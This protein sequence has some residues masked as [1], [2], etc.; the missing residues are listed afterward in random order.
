MDDSR[1]P[2]RLASRA[3]EDSG[4]AVAV[5]DAELVGRLRERERSAQ[6]A[7]YDR[8]AERL[9][10]YFLAKLRD[11]G[12]ADAY[13]NEVFVRAMEGLTDGNTTVTSLNGWLRGIAANLLKQHYEELSQAR[14]RHTGHEPPTE[15]ATPQDEPAWELDGDG[16][17]PPTPADLEFLL[18]KRELWT[19]VHAAADGIGHGLR[20]VFTAHLHLSVREKRKISAAE[21]AAELDMTPARVD[22]Q[23]SRARGEVL[24]AIP[25]LVVA[26]TGA[27]RCDGLAAMLEDL[28]TADQLAA[29]RALVLKPKQVGKVLGHTTSCDVCGERAADART[30]ARW[31]LPPALIAPEDDERRRT[32]IGWLGHTRDGRALAQSSTSVVSSTAAS[33]TALALTTPAARSTITAT[34]QPT[35]RGRLTALLGSWTSRHQGLHQA[36]VFVTQN[37]AVLRVAVGAAALAVVGLVAASSPPDTT[38]E[39]VEEPIAPTST[40]LPGA[41]AMPASTPS[42]TPAPT[43]TAA[44]STS[45]RQQHQPVDSPVTFPNPTAPA[46][47]PASLAAVPTAEPPVAPSTASSS[48]VG[49]ATTS[50]TTTTT[51]TTRT[52]G[53][54]S[55]AFDVSDTSYPHFYIG[56]I[57][58]RLAGDR[59]HEVEL[60]RGNHKLHTSSG[61]VVEFSLDA[62]GNVSYDPRYD[63]VVKGRGTR[64]LSLHG[65]PVTVDASD[66]DYP[67]MG[68][69]NVGGKAPKV[70]S[71]RLL[72]GAYVVASSNGAMQAFKVDGH[73]RVD[74][75]ASLDRAFGGRGTARLEVRG[76]PVEVDASATDYFTVGIS[77]IGAVT[78]KS[79]TAKLMPGAHAALSGAV[80]HPFTVTP[81]GTVDYDVKYREVLGGS[82]SGTLILQ[83][84]P[85]TVDARDTSYGTMSLYY[86]ESNV[87][88][89]ESRTWRLMPGPHTLAVTS[90]VLVRFQV[91]LD[92]TVGNV[93]LS[94]RFAVVRGGSTLEL[95]GGDVVVDV[96]GVSY[97]DYTL[98]WAGRAGQE[99]VK[100]WKLLPGKHEL[101][102][103]S[104]VRVYFSVTPAGTVDYDVKYGK[105]M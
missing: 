20:R 87:K 79:Y 51:T 73:G 62:G 59:V 27:S 63:Q 78:A 56:G 9:K 11:P 48:D 29:G 70:Y 44:A 13:V 77:G 98:A 10:P 19:T 66:T 25:A 26:R 15:I 89:T 35:R 39:A 24:K 12:E 6:L 60:A 93:G 72:P 69:I 83:G 58:D 30:L 91:G 67:N 65:L 7:L 90:G 95:H 32:L 46:A 101:F 104:L 18:G 74:Y 40:T 84:R 75:A 76:L 97:P 68:I 57:A 3:R 50:T 38:A 16:D 17:P 53:L 100:T 34:P 81:A 4:S 21:L 22:R 82:G 99:K 92:G 8:C 96:T 61:Q 47:T 86:V 37:P 31:A 103:T 71:W 49:P 28:L 41:V 14:T 55:V 52:G 80:S 5:G 2:A 64:A 1:L 94:D 85:V 36:V 45:T 54:V 88:A 42:P 33:S 43:P 105:A 23:L 102:M